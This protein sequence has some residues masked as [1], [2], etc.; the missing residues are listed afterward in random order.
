M[1]INESVYGAANSWLNAINLSTGAMKCKCANFTGG[2]T[3]VSSSSLG[4]GNTAGKTPHNT[5]IDRSISTTA[6]G[7]ESIYSHI[8]YWADS[9]TMYTDNEIA[10]EFF[11]CTNDNSAPISNT[12]EIIYS[13]NAINFWKTYNATNNKSDILV[14][15]TEINPKKILYLLHVM[16]VNANG[17]PAPF[18][19]GVVDNYR[20][21]FIG[22]YA[23]NVRNIRTDYPYIQAA[24]LVPRVDN[25]NT[26][27]PSRSALSGGDYEYGIAINREFTAIPDDNLKINYCQFI[28]IYDKFNIPLWG[29]RGYFN[30]SADYNVILANSEDIQTGVIEYSREYWISHEWNDEF[31]DYLVRQAACFGVF[32]RAFSGGGSAASIPLTHDSVILGLL[33]ERGIG[34]GDYTRGSDNETNP[35]FNWSSYSE[36]PYDYT[37]PIDPTPYND[38]TVFGD[39]TLSNTFIQYYAMSKTGLESLCTYIYNYI[40]SVDTTV[41]DINKA[42]SKTFYTNNPLDTIVS[43]KMFP[44]SI[45]DLVGGTPQ[46]IKL[47]HLSTGGAGTKLNGNYTVVDLGSYDCYPKFGNCFLDYSPYTYYELIIPFC[48]STRLDPSQFMGKTLRLKMAIDLYTGACTC[49]ILANNL[50]ID[51]LSGNCAV[52]MAITG[53]Q[54]ADFQNSMQNAIT[55]VKN[56]RINQKAWEQRGELAVGVVGKSIFGKSTARL[57]NVLADLGGAFNPLTLGQT[58]TN[59]QSKE[60][61]NIINLNQAEYNLQHM[62]TPFS[63]VGSQSAA[64]S[65]MEELQARLIIYRPEIAPDFDPQIYADTYGYATLENDTLNK[66]SGLTVAKINLAGVRCSDEERQMIENLFANGVYL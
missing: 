55:N 3:V 64:N 2:N 62:T 60:V 7:T 58:L 35:I 31:Y 50:C 38:R 24:R 8:L 20:F 16:P 44:F 17:E 18:I 12:D 47:G 30:Q 23:N 43:L 53:I 34:H 57:G 41:E 22:D 14:P 25:S 65:R 13:N 10:T 42:I 52:D 9:N 15:I 39:N 48:G 28:N 61:E 27:T 56:A 66:Y 32:V 4:I 63:A 40:N 36:S 5:L 11:Y 29:H 37:K 26:T 19:S 51:S 33:D 54:S 59:S 1:Q 49:Y 46:N 6:L 21:M 45:T